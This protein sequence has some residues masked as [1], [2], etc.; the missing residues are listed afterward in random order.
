M[1]KNNTET[2]LKLG[3]I[4]PFKLKSDIVLRS[5]LINALLRAEIRIKAYN[6]EY[7]LSENVKDE[8]IKELY[9]ELT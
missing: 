3:L 6:P 2:N 9:N 5:K 4:E 7:F 8:I 1:Y